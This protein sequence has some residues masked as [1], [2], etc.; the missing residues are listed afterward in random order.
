MNMVMISM[1]E[2]F[3]ELTEDEREDLENAAKQPVVYDEDC[4]ELTEEMLAQFKRV[5]WEERVKQTV[6]LRLSPDTLKKA[7]ALGK[8]YTSILSRLLDLAINDTEL[9][10]K[11][12]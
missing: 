7:K 5:N 12:L 10:K 3:Y 9:L 6:S 1:N 8:G 4:P 2:L 11:C